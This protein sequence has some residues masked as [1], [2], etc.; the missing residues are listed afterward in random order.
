[1]KRNSSNSISY[2]ESLPDKLIAKRDLALLR[3]QYI[4]GCRPGEVAALMFDNLDFSGELPSATIKARHCKNNKFRTVYFNHQVQEDLECWFDMLRDIGYTNKHIFPSL[5]N[6]KP[7]KP[8]Q[9][10]GIYRMLQRRLKEI[11]LPPR[12]A[13]AL[14]HSSAL[15]AIAKGIDIRKIRDQLGHSII[16]VTAKYLRKADP[17]RGIAYKNWK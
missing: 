3:F 10:E 11:E 15:H 4:T 14:R 5:V 1:M 17:D 9:S 7:G 13:H 12:K 2:L 8:L 16:V 6:G